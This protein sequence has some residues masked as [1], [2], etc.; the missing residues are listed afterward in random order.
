MFKLAHLL[1]QN[2]IGWVER[3]YAEGLVTARKC[4][5]HLWGWTDNLKRK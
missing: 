3:D 1:S 2:P 4:F 5:G